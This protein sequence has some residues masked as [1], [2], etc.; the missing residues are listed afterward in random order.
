V[1]AKKAVLLCSIDKNKN[2]ALA[3]L[4]V[5]AVAGA[6]KKGYNKTIN[7]VRS[8]AL[9]AASTGSCA[10]DEGVPAVQDLHPAAAWTW[11]QARRSAALPGSEICWIHA[12]LCAVCRAGRA[13][14]VCPAGS[15]Q[16]KGEDN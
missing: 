12:L 4:S 3:K 14:C 2:A 11:V 10:V 15:F 13:F 9:S 7:R 1:Q 5:S 8:C 16:P 6:G